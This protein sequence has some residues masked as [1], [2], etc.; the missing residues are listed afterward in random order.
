MNIGVSNARKTLSN[1]KV[2]VIIPVFNAEKYIRQC[3]DSLLSQ[4]LK[5]IEIIC[6]DDG[7]TDGSYQ[8]LEEYARKDSR[9]LY[10]SQQNLYAGIAR[11]AGLSRAIGEYILFLDADD[12]FAPSML[13][14]LYFKAKEYAAQMVIFGHYIYNDKNSKIT[15][16]PFSTKKT[17]LVS[18]KDLGINLF[19]AC[20]A[21]PWN[22]LLL[23]E[24]VKSKYLSYQGIMNNND[25]FFN[26][27]IVVDADKILF[28]NKRF[29]YYRINNSNSLQGSLTRNVLCFGEALKAVYDELNMRNKLSGDIRV[30]YYK[31]AIRMISSNVSKVSE[32][33]NMEKVFYYLKN[34]VIPYIFSDERI[35]EKTVPR[36]ISQA[37]S[38]G[39]FLFEYKKLQ[40]THIVSKDT[41][42]YKLG[43]WILSGPKYWIAS[44]FEK[45]AR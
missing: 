25:E 42:E 22:K 37:S 2:S 34:D 45:I 12:F 39:D 41:L 26:R 27:M 15:K 32:Y 30:T 17:Q 28:Y 13:K 43:H 40:E 1:V 38:C 16:V 33:S 44:V 3:L 23:R 20:G 9:V 19:E 11:N 5:E 8:I 36:L 18:S 31:Y 35:P 14:E 29:V 6:V 24:Y 21:T 4:T 10:Q 7:S